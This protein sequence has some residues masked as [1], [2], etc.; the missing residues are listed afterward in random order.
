MHKIVIVFAAAC[1]GAVVGVLAMLPW[2]R[3][4]D[5]LV[6]RCR[7]EIAEL[8]RLEQADPK[9]FTACFAA[10]PE[11]QKRVRILRAIVSAA[12]SAEACAERT[13]EEDVQEIPVVVKSKIGLR[14]FLPKELCMGYM[15]F[16]HGV[17]LGTA[18]RPYRYEK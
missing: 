11:L 4:D 2:L 10:N 17:Y 16:S 3:I 5:R 18:D 1:L 9:E 8:N 12:D 13:S 14:A 7:A 15:R 6:D